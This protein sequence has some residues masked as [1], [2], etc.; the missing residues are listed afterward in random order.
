MKELAE[1]LKLHL[2]E[3]VISTVV[4]KN[5][6]VGDFIVITDPDKYKRIEI[7][8][9]FFYKYVVTVSEFGNESM[10]LKVAGGQKGTLTNKQILMN[11]VNDNVITDTSD[12]GLKKEKEALKNK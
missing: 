9:G 4:L 3:H 8:N 2:K 1:Y 11:F 12:E 10:V 7:E 5:N 6:G